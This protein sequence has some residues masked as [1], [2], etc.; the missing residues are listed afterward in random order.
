MTKRQKKSLEYTGKSFAEACEF[1]NQRPRRFMD[2]EGKVIAT[3]EQ[4]ENAPFE[5]VYVPSKAVFSK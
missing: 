5:E 1:I 2:P 4:Y 3:P